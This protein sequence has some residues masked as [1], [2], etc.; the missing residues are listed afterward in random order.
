MAAFPRRVARLRLRGQ[1]VITDD[2]LAYGTVIVPLENAIVVGGDTLARVG[3]RMPSPARSRWT[4]LIGEYGWD[5]NILYVFE[6]GGV[7]HALIEWFFV[8]PLVEISRDELAFPQ[9]GGLYQ[10]ERLVFSRGVDGVATQVEAAGVVFR[11]RSIGESATGSTFTI[12]PVRPVAD[13]RAEALAASPPS[14][15]GEFRSSDLI[16]LQSLDPAIAYDIRYATTNNFMQAVFYDEPR[17][18]MQRPA[19]EALVRAHRA[20]RSRGLGLLIHDA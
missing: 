14:E 8:D 11:R 2:R 18:F 1:Q 10:G 6:K 9:T 5:H 7:L 13:L 20:L 4:G 12:D 16:E 19:A 3:D 17:A 15:A